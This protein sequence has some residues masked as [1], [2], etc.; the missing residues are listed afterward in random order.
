MSSFEMNPTFR[1]DPV[2]DLTHVWWAKDH[3]G[4]HVWWADG[5]GP[6]DT[7]VA[8]P[9]DYPKDA[10]WGWDEDFEGAISKTGASAY[11]LDVEASVKLPEGIVFRHDP[12]VG[13]VGMVWGLFDPEKEIKRPTD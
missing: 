9:W 6:D 7:Y 4:C 1:G 10:P 11:N 13:G 12:Q 5:N 3:S 8:A 2:W